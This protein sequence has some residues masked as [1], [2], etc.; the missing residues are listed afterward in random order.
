MRFLNPIHLQIRASAERCFKILA[1]SLLGLSWGTKAP[2]Q[3][4]V[5][6][7]MNA[8][9]AAIFEGWDIHMASSDAGSLREVANIIAVALRPNDPPRSAIN[10]VPLDAPSSYQFRYT[11]SG[12]VLAP[13][14]AWTVTYVIRQSRKVVAV[15]PE[16]T[17]LQPE[18]AD[19]FTQFP[20]N[21]PANWSSDPE[22][23]MKSLNLRSLRS[24]QPERPLPGTENDFEWSHKRI[25]LPAAR[26]VTA[27][28]KGPTDGSGI[29]IGHPDT[30]YTKNSQFWPTRVR[31]DLGKNFWL[32]GPPEP[33]D[34]MRVTIKDA[35]LFPLPLYFLG[36]G[37][38]TSSVLISPLG[39]AMPNQGP[40]VC[41]VAPGA[42]VI[43][44]RVSPSVVILNQRRLA[45][46]IRHAAN[47]GARVISISLGGLPSRYLDAAVDYA[48]GKNVIVCAAAGNQVG[49]VTAPAS[50]VHAIAVA[51]TNA[52]NEAWTGSSHG[53][54]VDV[55]APGEKVW[56]FSADDIDNAGKLEESIGVGSGT[57]FAV[58]H[59]AG[60]AAMWLSYHTPA[61]LEKKYPQAGMIPRVYKYIIQSTARKVGVIPPG[62]RAINW[63]MHQ[64]GK[65][66]L[67]AEAVMKMPL[68]DP[69]DV[70][71][72]T[73]PAP[74]GAEEMDQFARALGAGEALS[75]LKNVA[76]SKAA[77]AIR[78]LYSEEL[79]FRFYT[80]RD[81]RR[82]LRR[83]S[84]QP[85]QGM[86]DSLSVQLRS[87]L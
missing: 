87:N 81:F 22:G 18:A 4:M 30:G 58:T 83:P 74:P 54:S 72:M 17:I 63:N 53:P 52:Y 76:G 5:P 44:E 46:A 33:I 43:P 11:T 6:A 35:I 8:A 51:G 86:R 79:M 3:S 70:P 49:F 16:F 78:I 77:E 29:L 40:F 10:Y 60:V 24:S 84:S 71:E 12:G 48:Y 38:R 41:G 75:A 7:Q 28:G 21:A 64:Y 34:P 19:E 13:G 2:A 36:H 73:K 69:K 85:S 66:L 1:L 47:Q 55:S 45:D 82:E 42:K 15:D 50:C 61:E 25:N 39:P 32:S 37:T 23:A 31:P 62:I 59:V 56:R 14:A 20:I 27:P 57:S 9:N 67:D 26:Q 65:G 80:D 68:P